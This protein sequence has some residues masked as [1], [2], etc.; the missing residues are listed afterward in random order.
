MRR[1]LAF[2]LALAC[3]FCAVP[4]MA[5]EGAMRT[6]VLIYMSGS[7]LESE[8]G[9]ATADIQEML[10]ANVPADGPLSVLVETG[11]AKKWQLDGHPDDKNCLYRISGEDC[12]MLETLGKRSMGAP[13]S[14]SAFLEYG[15]K[16]YP[17]DRYILVLWGHGDGSTG[18]VCFDELFDDDSL[19]LD[20]IAA[21][22]EDAS[23]TGQNIEALIFDACSM[24]CADLLFSLGGCVD[25]IVASQE[26]TLG[27]GGRYDLWLS[28]L[29]QSP[30]MDALEICTRFA[31]DYVSTGSHGLFSQATT[32][33][34][35]DCG[36]SGALREAVEALYGALN[37][38]F[39]DSADEICAA[40]SQLPS[41]GELDGSP[42]SGLMDALQLCDA[43]EAFAPEECT[44]LRSAV[45]QAVRFHADSGALEGVTCGLS[46]FLPCAEQDWPDELYDWYQPLADE[47]DYARLIVRMAQK[48]EVGLGSSLLG[49][50]RDAFSGDYESDS[51]AVDMQHIW[52]GLEPNSNPAANP[53]IAQ[54]NARS[55]SPAVDIQHIW[56]GLEPAA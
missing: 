1:R 7:D 32:A 42:P 10:R 43:L 22:L 34:V 55:D 29:A 54:N 20:E 23:Q 41:F 51:P 8:D 50:L 44:R 36:A 52:Q 28:A 9:S 14:L 38:R 6:T 47:S 49:F 33:S 5:A 19:M 21:A 12:Q 16:N 15:R 35:L 30:E 2:L 37:L 18:G 11:G 26:S 48:Q 4:A 17:A 56:Q 3:V 24:N 46:L 45:N 31:G 40:V 53:E 13:D 39:D 25:Y 27:S